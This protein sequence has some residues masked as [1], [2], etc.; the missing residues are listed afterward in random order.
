MYEEV[1]GEIP[2]GYKR[3][4]APSLVGVYRHEGI[5]YWIEVFQPF[6]GSGRWWWKIR[7]ATKTEL[8]YL[9]RPLSRNLRSLGHAVAHA[10]GWL[11]RLLEIE[12]KEV[13]YFD[14][15]REQPRYLVR[16]MKGTRLRSIS[17]GQRYARNRDAQKSDVERAREERLHAS[18]GY[19]PTR[20]W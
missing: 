12:P 9:D 11:Y 17:S 20:E 14:P 4:V 10:E 15:S 5:R 2:P 7:K 19:A 1:G 13:W 6:E 18:F 3:G 8:H 16:R